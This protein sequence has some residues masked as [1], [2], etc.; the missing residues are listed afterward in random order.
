[1]KQR[2]QSLR[3]GSRRSLSAALILPL[4][5]FTAAPP[6]AAAGGDQGKVV[7]FVKTKVKK[8]DAAGKVIEEDRALEKAIVSVVEDKGRVV[9]GGKTDLLGAY[10]FQYDEGVKRLVIKRPPFF[11]DEYREKVQI[12]KDKPTPPE[13]TYLVRDKGNESRA[14]L[15]RAYLEYETR[16]VDFKEQI[17]KLNELCELAEGDLSETA[18]AAPVDWKQIYVGAQAGAVTPP[19]GGQPPAGS[20]ECGL[21]KATLSAADKGDIPSAKKQLDRLLT[22]L[23]LDPSVAGA[24]VPP[25]TFS[26]RQAVYVVAFRRMAQPVAVNPAGVVGNADYFD[27]D[28]DTERKVRKELEEWGF[29]RVVNKLGE[30]DFVFL[31]TL[32]DSSAE[33]VALPPAAYRKHFKEDFDRDALRDEAYGYYSVGPLNLPTVSRL[34]GRLVKQFRENLMRTGV[35]P[36]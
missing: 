32:E 31:V 3:A 25:F 14:R 36:R 33:G 19:P 4:A 34:T 30:A 29:F 35:M 18:V 23:G 21:V 7:G 10:R 16:F 6:P 2:V 9:E 24:A 13:V 20:E 15:A 27:D 1:M 26:E 22:L 8:K 11:K 28:L 5:L 12:R 17:G